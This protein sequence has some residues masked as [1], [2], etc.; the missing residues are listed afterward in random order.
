MMYRNSPF[1]RAAGLFGRIAGLPRRIRRNPDIRAGIS[2]P[3]RYRAEL[4][5]K[6]VAFT[7]GKPDSADSEI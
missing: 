7:V 2:D 6:A 5:R 1:P 4:L 3:D